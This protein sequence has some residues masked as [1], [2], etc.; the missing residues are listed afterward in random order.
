[1][2][3][4]AGTD[5]HGT[6]GARRSTR[7]PRRNRLLPG[8]FADIGTLEGR[9]GNV[10]GSQVH[11]DGRDVDPQH[12][13]T[14]SGQGQCGRPP[15]SAADVQD[16]A[17][18][19]EIAQQPVE[20]GSVGGRSAECPLVVGTQLVEHCGSGAAAYLV[21]RCGSFPCPLRS[22]GSFHHSPPRSTPHPGPAHGIRWT[23]AHGPEERGSMRAAPPT[24]TARKSG[25]PPE[26]GSL[27]S[28]RTA[29]RARSAARTV[30]SEGRRAVRHRAAVVVPRS[31]YEVFLVSSCARCGLRGPHRTP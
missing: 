29:R 30:T 7:R 14:G 3:A 28:R 4:G 24:T 15:R 31:R 16:P 27:H 5:P 11:H 22:P 8:E 20:R 23:L 9:A 10:P 18:R 21:H 13:M 1:M 12:L 6:S 17:V 19:R 26:S 25:S 2:C